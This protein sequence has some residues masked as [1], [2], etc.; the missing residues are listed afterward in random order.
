MLLAA[1][2]L[3]PGIL[4]DEQMSTIL[5][6]TVGG[7]HQPILTSVKENRPDYVCFFCTGRDPDTGKRGSIDQVTGKGPVIKAK[8][9]DDKPTLPNITVQAGLNDDSFAV[10]KRCRLTTLMAPA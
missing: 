7:S 5:L 2:W 1:S 10:K 8:R 6:C 9:E 3:L 4:E